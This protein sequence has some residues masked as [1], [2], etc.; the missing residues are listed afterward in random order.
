[1]T[2]PRRS[3]GLIIAIISA[4]A[5]ALSGPLAKPLLDAGW[6]A[7]AAVLVRIGGAAV[8]LLIPVLMIS[9]RTRGRPLIDN[10]RFLVGYGV[11]P[12]AGTQL[13][14]FSAIQT[15]PVGVALLIEYLAP[16]FVVGWLWLRRGQRPGRLTVA[17]AGIA[18]V[19]LVLVLNPTSPAAL[20]LVGVAW[21]LL[22]SLCL[23]VYFIASATVVDDL[24]P[25]L[26]IGSGLVVA[27]F[28]IAAVG[29]IGLL[30][31]T[32]V[33]TDAEL[34]GTALPWWVFAILLILVGTVFAYLT[35]VAA[36]RRLGPRLASFVALAEVVFATLV[37]WLLLAQV[38]TGL[39]LAGGLSILAG[40]VLVRLGERPI[41]ALSATPPE[42]PEPSE[43]VVSSQIDPG[44]H[45]D[46]VV[47][48]IDHR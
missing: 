13:G 45:Q 39:Q 29:L 11:F 46:P 25:I 47:G 24:S 36:A 22:A 8:V 48:E 43:V 2:T 20:D 14:F 44:E 40:V 12:I 26:V 19:G 6:S 7:G 38:P 21:A 3:S 31:L 27:W 35:G 41:D 16:V 34:A 9:M 32:V 18:V 42:H 17:G 1:M 33:T 15:L 23:V 37:A 10:W 28:V 4:A 30:P 5:F